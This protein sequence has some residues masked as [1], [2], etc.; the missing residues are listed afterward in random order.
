MKSTK[1]IVLSAMF[2][3]L[4]LVLPFLTMQIGTLGQVLLPMHYPV[5]LAAFVCGPSYAAVIGFICPLLRSALFGMPP[6]VPTALAMAFELMTYGLITGLVFQKQ[7]NGSLK[8]VYI[9][10]IA[11]MLAGRVVW[12]LAMMI[13]LGVQGSDFTMAAFLSGAFTT[14][15]PGI[16]IQ[17]I[18]I[19][20][21]VKALQKGHQITA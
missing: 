3:A 2:L 11:G 9:A 21:I 17:L 1:K 18:L 14:A 12:G 16:V 5:F 4:G 7:K 20:L 13:I 6:L 8:A 19:P 10:L 15:L